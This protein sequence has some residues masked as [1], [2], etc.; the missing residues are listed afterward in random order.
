MTATRHV[1][2]NVPD[3][4][5]NHCK[6]AIESA[7]S[8]LAGVD[9]VEVEIESKSVAVDLDAAADLGAV[10]AAIE[11]AGLPDRRGARVRSL[12]RA[13]RRGGAAPGRAGTIAHRVRGPLA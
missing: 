12:R 8:G 6:M 3:V 2:L 1:V 5:C 13:G 11:E 4:S 9:A 7:V 10:R